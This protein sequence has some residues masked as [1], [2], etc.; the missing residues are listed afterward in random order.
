MSYQYKTGFPTEIK[1]FKIHW[2]ERGGC[3]WASL[4]L[5]V[6]SFNNHAELSVNQ[7]VFATEACLLKRP[8]GFYDYNLMY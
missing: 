3:I 7:S 4:L 8:K 6:W 5:S 1:C 2:Y